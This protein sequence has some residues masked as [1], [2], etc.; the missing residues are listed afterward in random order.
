MGSAREAHALPLAL[1]MGDPAGIGVEIA[2]KAWTKRADLGLVPFAFYGDPGLV[3]ARMRLL[4]LTHPVEV[5]SEPSQ[6]CVLF[7]AALPVLP[8]P[9]AAPA[10]PGEPDAANAPA[11]IGAIERAVADVAHGQVRGL[12][13]APIAKSV[14]YAAGFPHPGHTEFL[15]ALATRHWPGRHWHPVMMLASDALRVVPLTI[16]VPLADVPKLISRRA[17]G[18]TVRIIHDA[19]RNQFGIE[20]PRIAVAGLNPH[21]GEEGTIGREDADIIAPAIR[22]LRQEGLAVSGPHAADT[23]FHEQARRTYDAVLGMYHD[24][25]LIPI[26]TLA[27]DEGV[28]VTLGLPFVR[29]SPDHGT[30]FGIAKQGVANPAS[31]IE[32]IRLADRLAPARSTAQARL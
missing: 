4:G 21:A 18:E 2:I 11:T 6:A 13:T 24:Q 16:H 12:V 25:V 28:N 22:D 5:I 20:A 17:I 27:F 31:M 7:S 3:A 14:L 10:R 30:A 23:L 29:T 26:K 15:A 32:A 9:L 8:I 1:T 19:L